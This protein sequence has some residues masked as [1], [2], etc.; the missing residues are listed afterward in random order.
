MAVLNIDEQA[1]IT[2]AISLAESRTSGEIRI[3]VEQVVGKLPVAD[4]A[5]KFFADLGMHKT[6][7]RNGVLIYLAVVDRQFAILG[8]QGIHAH[9]GDD[10]WESIKEKMIVHFRS[11]DYVQ[12]L[13]EG[14]TAAGERLYTFFPRQEDDINELPNEIHFGSN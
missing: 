13:V 11:G 9:V 2:H 3:V 7:R 12:G 6:V 10:F 8:D 4:R 14:I 5:A 1:K